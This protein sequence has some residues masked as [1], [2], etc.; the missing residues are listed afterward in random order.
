MGHFYGKNHA[1][2]V[3][4]KLAP[5]PFLILP[6][7]PKQT[8]HEGN[9]FQNKKFWDDYQK[10]LKKSTLFFLLHPVPFNGCK[11]IKNKR[12][13]KLVTSCSSG[14]ETCSEKSLY[15]LYIIWPSLIV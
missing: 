9:S 10:P 6:N 1:E 14:Y 2:N 12:G 13:L 11:V 7:N 15:L 8:L 3:H 5:D 4:Q